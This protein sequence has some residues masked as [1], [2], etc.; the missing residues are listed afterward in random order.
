L[1]HSPYHIPAMVAAGIDVFLRVCVQ[2]VFGGDHHLVPDTFGQL[3][4]N[5]FT[6]SIRIIVGRVDKI[7][8][9]IQVGIE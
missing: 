9:L 4:Y 6:A 1:F 2:R 3:T 5:G 8:A 7:A